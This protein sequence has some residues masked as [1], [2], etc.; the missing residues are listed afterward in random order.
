MPICRSMRRHLRLL[1]PFLAVVVFTGCQTKENPS[2]MVSMREAPA[3][4]LSYRYEADVP[5]PSLE[6]VRTVEER[7]TA[8]QADFDA[9]RPQ[10]GLD[11]T[12]TS[13]DRHHTV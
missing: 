6:A 5:A 13:P 1:L 7:N 4:R 8:V 11:R 2:T 12:V 9:R 3:V 10:E